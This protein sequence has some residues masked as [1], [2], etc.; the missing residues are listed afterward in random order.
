MFFKRKAGTFD[1]ENTH[2]GDCRQFVSYLVPVGT[3]ETEI[4][5]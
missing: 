4:P 3:V 2:T 5:S 1:T